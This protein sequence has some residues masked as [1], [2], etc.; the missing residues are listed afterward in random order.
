MAGTVEPGSQ[1]H[2]RHRPKQVAT[3]FLM[4]AATNLEF[5][6]LFTFWLGGRSAPFLGL[7]A[8]SFA[9][10]LFFFPTPGKLARKVASL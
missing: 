5:L 8:V 2:R 3:A 7:L 4:T 10:K 6:G 9:V 1:K